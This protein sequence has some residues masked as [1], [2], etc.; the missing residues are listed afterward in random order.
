MVEKNELIVKINALLAEEFE[1]E[2]RLIAPEKSLMQTLHLDSL[3]RLDLV[4]LIEKY[5]G[6]KFTGKDFANITTFQS[7]YDCLYDRLKTIA[8]KTP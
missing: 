1:I 2:E 4:V 5:F 6:Y 7:F 8:A 3:D